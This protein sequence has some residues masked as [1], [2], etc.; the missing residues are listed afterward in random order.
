MKRTICVAIVNAILLFTTVY[1]AAYELNVDTYNGGDD[2]PTPAPRSILQFPGIG[3]LTLDGNL[4][5][6][7]PQYIRVRYSSAETNWAIRVITDNNGDIGGVYPKPLEPG[8]DGQW[9]WERLRNPGYSMDRSGNWQIGD[10][11][12]TF[13]G[14]INSSTKQDP[15]Q[16][17]PLAWQVFRYNDPY[18]EGSF[19]DE[20]IRPTEGNDPSNP[21]DDPND[22]P[23]PPPTD[24]RDGERITYTSPGG[25]RTT[26]NYV[27]GGSVDDWVYV[28]DVSDTGYVANPVHSY[29]WVAYGSGGFSFLAQHPVVYWRDRDNNGVPDFNRDGRPI[30]QPKPGGGDCIIYVGARFGRRHPDGT[31]D[32]NVL[33]PGDYETMIYL[34]LIHW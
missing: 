2:T 21:N 32:V 17:A 26:I 24:L 8:A 22:L 23:S 5:I 20:R 18:Y 28:A 14:L 4:W 27:G 9:E 19:L 33:S 10:D 1:I 15:N 6:A 12:V 29:F 31:S 13:S 11:V 3:G 25:V 7:S 16:R 30:A 34:E